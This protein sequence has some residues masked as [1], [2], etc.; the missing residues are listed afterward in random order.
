MNDRLYP[1]PV[2]LLLQSLLDEYK[3]GTL[4]GY[5]TS[6]F[7]S[8]PD[9]A[10]TELARFGK[11]LDTPLGLAAGPHTQ[12][13]H[14]IL[15][16]WLFG[17][18]FI[19][20]KTVQVLDDIDI[21]KPCIDM[22]AEGY[23]SE[24]S[25]ELSVNESLN[26]YLHAWVLIHVFNDLLNKGRQE[27][28]T[29]FNL[30]VGYDLEGIKSDKISAFLDAATNSKAHIRSIVKRLATIY[31]RVES[32][33]IP[34]NMSDNIT[35]ST[36]HGCPPEEIESIA[37]YL[38]DRW[39]LHTTVK[40]NPTLLGADTLRALFHDRL[41]YPINVPDEAFA[42]DIKYTEAVEMIQRLLIFADDRNIRFGVKL[43]NTL[44]TLNERKRFL[45]ESDNLYMSGS[46]LHPIAVSLAAK[47]QQ[48]F[49]GALDISF[50]GG[51]DAFNLPM[52]VSAGLSPVTVS[53]DLLKPAGYSRLP[54]YIHLLQ[55]EMEKYSANSIDDF[56][57]RKAGESNIDKAALKN[58]ILYAEEVS[59]NDRYAHRTVNKGSIKTIRS[60]EAFDCVSAPCVGSC[61]INQ[62][63]PEYMFY[64]AKGDFDNALDII[65]RDNPLP[66]ITGMVCDHLCQTKCTRMNID[67][68][69]H[70]REIKR[71]IAEAAIKDM[72]PPQY[73]N[74]ISAGIIGA[75]PAGLS[76]AFFLMREGIPVDIYES[77]ESAG[78]MVSKAIPLFRIG[79][80]AVETDTDFLIEMGVK[81]H[82]DY[83]I[84]KK[85]FEE[86]RNKHDYLFI[87]VGAAV[88][89]SLNIPGEE[90][91]NVFDQISFLSK[92]KKNEITTT[93]KSA[94]VIGGGN[95]AIDAARTA[96][97]LTGK[98]GSVTVIYRRTVN[99]MP[100][101]RD[102]IR[103]LQKEGIE[104][105]ELTS[106]LE[107][108]RTNN[109]LSLLCIQNKLGEPDKS[110]RRRP[111]PINGS[112]YTLS[113]D[114][115]ISAIGQDVK[116]DFLPA[117]EFTINPETL[118]TSLDRVFA[119]GD[120]IRGADTLIH[121]VRDGK[122]AAAHILNDAG[123]KHE[124]PSEGNKTSL[125]QHQK[126]SAKRIY[127]KPLPELSTDERNSFDLVHPA[128]S[129]EDAIEEAKRC[130]Y[131]DEICNI[132]VSVCP[133]K[134]IHYFENRAESLSQKLPKEAP[135]ELIAAAENFRV[136][137]TYQIA[138][139]ADFCNLCGNCE[140]FCPTSG[141]PYKTK[142]RF[143]LSIDSYISDTIGFRLTSEGINYK[144]DGEEFRLL[145]VNNT[146]KFT[147]RGQTV[148][149]SG[150]NFRIIEQGAKS[151]HVVDWNLFC[152]MYFLYQNVN[153][154]P[155]FS[156]GIP[157]SPKND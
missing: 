21:P 64:T 71:V 152:E 117:G 106:P 14:N 148:S 31:P 12:L 69:L 156:A 1:L 116:L 17:A 7:Y 110:G 90:L 16:G 55:Q 81:F 139:I 84:N 27:T 83:L 82:F 157:I 130:L 4:F 149:L 42:H 113:F 118:K 98:D 18:R 44:E 112:E 41:G 88:G 13:S 23:N 80:E 11:R 33:T 79:S 144:S 126:D 40:L 43:T 46:P 32:I 50:C 121:A 100:A 154:L 34:D 24:W 145:F 92:V 137:Q 147:G 59:N 57:K 77:S 129:K 53:T 25:Q 47:L 141:A 109:T 107:I 76:A 93:G 15:L 85:R 75:G 29:I 140:T 91:D 35:L 124:I 8:P 111:V 94:A 143:H 114:T 102:E 39:G 128:M 136:R 122:L 97:R 62:N 155:L 3:N 22:R 48:D 108:S 61:S 30:S 104:I 68:S 86:L 2:D 49:D 37:E 133:N 78:G 95:S 123:L 101:D 26:E 131:C 19:E 125:L 72:K 127:P 67:A 28:G 66:H 56:M 105:V 119:G 65:Y 153:T 36:M 58:L 151:L 132:C 20:L 150:Y 120:A 6:L 63:I 60:L 115:I 99:E 38:M 74:D 142:P 9:T 135:D 89:K 103:A 134:A 51:A 96:K 138:V 70:I 73:R 54:Q 52:L 5:D 146:I 45:T 87:A 10:A